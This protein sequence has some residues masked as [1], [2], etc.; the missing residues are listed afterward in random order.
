MPKWTYGIN[1]GLSY[2]SWTLELQ[3]YG[4]AGFMD[5]GDAPWVGGRYN[6]RKYDYWT[7]ENTNAKY[8]KP[9]FSEAGADSYYQIIDTANRSYM[10][11][12]NVSLSYNFPKSILGSSKVSAVK[13]YLQA[14]NLG[15][16][17]NNSE[18]RDL[19]TNQTYYNRGFTFGA[20]IS[21]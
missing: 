12:R 7:P 19:D 10:K 1:T 18:V 21:F 2:K 6:V 14:R 9:I 20:N 8:T 17:W 11:L 3:F 13:L 15:S 16:L 5:S 4:R